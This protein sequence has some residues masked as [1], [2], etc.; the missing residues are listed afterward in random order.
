MPSTPKSGYGN[1]DSG[2]N[3]GNNPLYLMIAIIVIIVIGGIAVL[4]LV[5]AHKIF[6]RPAKV[7]GEMRDDN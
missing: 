4:A 3:N 1:N 6:D 7:E 2:D 5:V